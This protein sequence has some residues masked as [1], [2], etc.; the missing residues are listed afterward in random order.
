M[1]LGHEHVIRT[2]SQ[3]LTPKKIHIIPCHIPPHKA[4]LHVDNLHRLAMLHKVFDGISSD[5]HIDTREIDSPSVSYTVDTVTAL[6]QELGEAVSVSF[7]VGEDSWLN[8]FRWF[9]WR[10]ILNKVNLVVVTRR[11]EWQVSGGDNDRKE[12][13]AYRELH[14]VPMVN[15]NDYAYGKIAKL[16]M[17]AVDIAS[18]TIRDCVAK[19]MSIDEMVSPSVASYIHEHGLYC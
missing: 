16:P 6:R 18:N 2:V 9:C 15:L 4:Q 1:H 7:V 14:E 10:E 5:V 19:G 13:H 11:G 3:Q 17:V 12:L 8:F